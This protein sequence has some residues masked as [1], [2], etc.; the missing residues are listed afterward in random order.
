MRG[1]IIGVLLGAVLGGA[2]G[3]AAGL[4]AFPLLFP[5]TPVNATV[6]EAE[7]GPV[8]ATGTFIHADPSDRVRW[9]T[10]TVAVYD[11]L[12]HLGADFEVG[13]GPKYH[14]YLVPQRAI[15]PDTRVEETM[16]VDLGPLRAF[17][18][19]QGYGIPAGVAL[20]DFGSVVIWCEQLNMLISTAEL[21]FK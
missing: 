9:G 20:Q 3:F 11:R 16:F 12:I 2:G 7:A 8:R 19:A 14:V 13:P 17:N 21:S 18:G 15:D 4:F 1:A 10:G 5:P 6:N